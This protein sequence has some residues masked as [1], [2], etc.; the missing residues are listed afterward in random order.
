MRYLVA[1]ER[2][3]QEWSSASG[4]MKE[5]EQVSVS[6]KTSTC[7]IAPRMMRFNVTIR[8]QGLEVGS[9]QFTPSSNV[10]VGGH[11]GN[12]RHRFQEILPQDSAYTLKRD[13]WLTRRV[14]R[15]Y[16]M[17]QQHNNSRRRN[18]WVIS[19]R[20]CFTHC[21]SSVCLRPELQGGRSRVWYPIWSSGFFIDLIL[22]TTLWPWSRVSF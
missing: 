1:V 16:W 8:W 22:P 18:S 10:F 12:T 20:I 7:F 21:G 15:F 13:R 2:S 4:E 5:D 6:D 19:R 17:S 11:T 9:P 14:S 3:G